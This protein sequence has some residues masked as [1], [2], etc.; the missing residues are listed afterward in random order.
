M[1]LTHWLWLFLVQSIWAASYMHHEYRAELSAAF[2]SYD[3]ATVLPG[4]FWIQ[5]V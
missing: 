3:P 1:H 4:S 5:R 2:R